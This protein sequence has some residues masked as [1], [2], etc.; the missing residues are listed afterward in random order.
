MLMHLRFLLL[1]MSVLGVLACPGRAAQMLVS[2]N[3]MDNSNPGFV[4]NLN[5]LGHT[6]TFVPTDSF[7]STSLTGFN[8]VWLDGFSFYGGGL[9]AQ[10][11]S[12][13]NGGGTVLVQNPGFGTEQIS[14]YP[15][16]SSLTPVYTIPPGENLIRIAASSHP[17]NAGLTGSAL[18]GWTPSAGGYFSTVGDFTVLTDNGTSGEAIT[19]AQAVGA[20]TLVYTQQGLSQRLAS[21]SDPA[22]LLLL[23]NIFLTAVP[24][25]GVFGLLALGAG[26]F[27]AVRVR[28]RSLRRERAAN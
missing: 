24:E 13:L 2:G 28:V 19:L 10:L 12:F 8:A 20:G 27:S 18:S 14:D 1:V 26:M 22:A 4:A 9:S 6:Y 7:T 3:S 16:G 25:P 21:T 5:S 11:T 23:N 15:L 17:I